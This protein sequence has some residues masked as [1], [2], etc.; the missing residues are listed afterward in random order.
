[1]RVDGLSR[2]GFFTPHGYNAD[3]LD[4]W[5]SYFYEA[6]HSTHFNAI[7]REICAKDRVVSH[8]LGLVL[9]GA[10]AVASCCLQCC[11][12]IIKVAAVPM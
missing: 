8:E 3:G 9:T 2:Q 4:F 5:I 10:R 11:A 1:M 12:L 6:K 7:I